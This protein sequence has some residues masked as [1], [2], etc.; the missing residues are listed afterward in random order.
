MLVLLTVRASEV[1]T[2]PAFF[3]LLAVTPIVLETFFQ[4]LEFVVCLYLKIAIVTLAVPTVVLV[5]IGW[6]LAGIV[7]LAGLEVFLSVVVRASRID[8]FLIV[9]LFMSLA[10]PPVATVELVVLVM[11]V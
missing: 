7:V 5:V 4:R 1:S 9:V 11:F 8:T 10:P 6:V 2:I 3:L